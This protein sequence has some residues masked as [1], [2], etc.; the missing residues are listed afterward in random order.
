M[1]V[2]LY[3]TVTKPLAAI[4]FKSKNLFTENNGLKSYIILCFKMVTLTVIILCFLKERN[5]FDQVYSQISTGQHEGTNSSPFLSVPFLSFPFLSVPFRS[6]LFFSVLLYS[7]LLDSKH[8]ILFI[9]FCSILFCYVL[10]CSLLSRLKPCQY[11]KTVYW[12][13]D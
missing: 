6:V 10:F 4:A 8:S 13:C 11:R 2:L 7:I 3:K 1:T 5:R 12:H 9:L